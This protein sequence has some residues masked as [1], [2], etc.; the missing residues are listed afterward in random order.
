M[1]GG[2]LYDPQ[3]VQTV[4]HVNQA[5][6]AHKLFTRDV[7]YIVRDDKLIII[8]EFTG[9]MMEGRRYSDGLHQAL[10]AKEHVSI[11][12]ENQTLASITFQNYFRL[13]PKLAGM[14]GTALTEAAE[15]SEIYTLD[16]VEVPT[17]VDV[18]REDM[19]D[20]VYGTMAE[21][22]EA[23]I[24]RIEECRTLGQP[25]LVGT[26]SIEKSEALA[27]SL[28]KRG[29]PHNVLNARFHDSEATIIAQAG[30]AWRRDHRH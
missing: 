20:E 23:I 13:Y 17:N 6:R 27:A 21:K 19:E 14:T 15:F 12:R 22:T 16:V 3:N 8:D 1:P 5:L 26:V 18:R 11:Q 9:R 10:E 28:K 4:H 2:G 25:V 29:V 24:K 7:D 30:S